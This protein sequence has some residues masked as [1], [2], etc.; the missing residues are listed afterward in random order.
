MRIEDYDFVC[1]AATSQ[2]IEVA[3]SRRHGNGMNSFWLTDG[4]NDFPYINILAKGDVAYVHYF[5]EERH[6]GFASAAK[7]PVDKPHETGVF[8]LYPTEKVWILNG[9]VI[10]FSDALKAAKEFA[11][12]TAMPKSIQWFEL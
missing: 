1:E 7:V 8:F 6:P 2:E 5:P 9:E 10:P 12:T 11:I 3:L 4:N